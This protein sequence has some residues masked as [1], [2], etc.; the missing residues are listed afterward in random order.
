MIGAALF[1]RN[2]VVR[3][4]TGQAT[5]SQHLC[6]SL[7]VGLIDH[8]L[9]SARAARTERKPRSPIIA[10]RNTY[11]GTSLRRISA[12]PSDDRS[13]HE[14]D[15]EQRFSSVYGIG[16]RR[17]PEASSRFRPDANQSWDQ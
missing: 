9:R 17:Y 1:S 16:L 3:R 6:R 5:Y 13:R 10:G 2:K 7:A 4:R 8:A 15:A 11:V 12:A 14:P